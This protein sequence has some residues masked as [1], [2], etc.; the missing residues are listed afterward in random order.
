MKFIF[1]Y[2]RHR[3]ICS[4][5]LFV[6]VHTWKTNLRTYYIIDSTLLIYLQYLLEHTRIYLVVEA[7]KTVGDGYSG[8]T[9]WLLQFS[10]HRHIC[11]KPISPTACSE[12]SCTHCGPKVS[13]WSYHACS[14]WIAL[15]S[16]SSQNKFQD[17][18]HHSHGPAISAAPPTSLH[19]F[20]RYAPISQGG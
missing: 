10:S 19:S 4:A 3:H 20:P 2:L 5:Q 6:N 7:A 15:A 13:L 8:I 9:A 17:S 16:R 11:F 1:L 14:V 12:Y 18:C